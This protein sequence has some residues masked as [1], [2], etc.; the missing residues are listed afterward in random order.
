[1]PLTTDNRCLPEFVDEH[2]IFVAP[3][4]VEHQLLFLH[5][6]IGEADDGIE[7]RA[8]FMTHRGEEA[9]LGLI[10]ARGLGMRIDLRLLQSLVLGDVA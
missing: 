7:R 6:H 2:G 9:A 4:A 3:L 1:M 8:Q 5:Q 10:G